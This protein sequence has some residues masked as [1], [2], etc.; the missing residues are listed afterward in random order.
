M[1]ADSVPRL[2]DFEGITLAQ[3]EARALLASRHDRKYV[4]REDI[5][6]TV[7]PEWSRNFDVLE[8]NGK[9]S[10]LYRSLY[11]DEPGYRSFHD[12]HQGRRIRFKVR[13]RHYV[14]VDEHY[15][16]LK[17]KGSRGRTLK[18]RLAYQA[19]RS[20]MLDADAI[21]HIGRTYYDVYRRP[22]QAELVPTIRVDYNR[23][24]LVA[25]Q[26]GMR[27]TIDRNLSFTLGS[28]T[29]KVDSGHVILETKSDRRR[30]VADET[31]RRM[32]QHPVSRCSKYC[33]GLAALGRVEKFNN[34]RPAM[35]MLK[36]TSGGI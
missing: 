8:I 4:V 21:E 5:L 3:L 10:F 20:A 26:G 31:L 25:K 23:T 11:F 1:I 18:S 13:T 17:L 9:T 29:C 33:I 24:T 14:D 27:I 35:Q 16:E 15:L 12:H 2:C 19:E 7:L 34:F 36:V 32:H 30:T 6:D 28:E 22:W